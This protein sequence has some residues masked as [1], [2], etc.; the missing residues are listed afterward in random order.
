MP[1]DFAWRAAAIRAGLH[2][3]DAIIAPSQAHSRSLASVY[4]FADAH[5]VHNGRG[6]RETLRDEHDGKAARPVV[7]AAGRLWDEG[8]NIGF[9]D[10]V[11]R[12][13]DG[14]F[15]A[16]GP[17]RGPHGASISLE[18]ILPLVELSP[19]GMASCYAQACVFASPARY[20]PF[21]LAVLEA[22]QAGLALVL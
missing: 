11:A 15:V 2:A 4:G 1:A 13:V 18:T 9:L 20:E 10:A 3:A 16:A 7:L 12:E 5:V 19:A 6:P 14:R 8:K 17:L 21:G 22:A